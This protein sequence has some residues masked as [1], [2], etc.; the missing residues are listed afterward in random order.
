MDVPDSAS[1]SASD[2]DFDKL[3]SE[4][5]HEID[6]LT[7]ELLSNPKQ[8]RKIALR[9][10]PEERIK[11]TEEVHRFIKYKER[12]FD[13][14]STLLDEYEEDDSTNSVV[15]PALHK[16]F[17]DFIRNLMSEFEL[18]HR[19]NTDPSSEYADDDDVMFPD[20]KQPKKP[21]KTAG[22]YSDPYS[23]WGNV[24]IT[25]RDNGSDEDGGGGG[26]GEYI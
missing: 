2:S 8:L 15:N 17:K 24:S 6:T 22:I 20:K 14:F 25:K 7:L 11:R 1:A 18:S 10:N 16:Q 19:A 13:T 21:K 12:I 3:K 5:Q 26:E 4:R 23:F 9:N